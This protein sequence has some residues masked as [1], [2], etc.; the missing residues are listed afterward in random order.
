MGMKNNPAIPGRAVLFEPVKD[1]YGTRLALVFGNESKGGYCPFYEKHCT[2]CDLGGGEGLAFD[3]KMNLERLEFFKKHYEQTLPDVHHL[4]LYNSGS[5]LNP[6]ELSRKTLKDIID[7]T[8]SLADCKVVSFDSRELYVTDANIGYIVSNLREDQQARIILGI[9]SQDD[10]IRMEKLNKPMSRKAIEN[11]FAAAGKYEGRVGVDVNIIF[12][13][14]ELVGEEA[15]ADAVKTAE[16]GL[17]LGER[18]GVPVDLNVHPYY[19]S[20]KGVGVFPEHS[21][22]DISDAKKALIVIKELL[23]ARGSEANLFVG[24]ED[25]AHDQEQD[26]RTAELEH[27]LELFHRFN[28]AQDAGLLKD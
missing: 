3:H 15:I 13:P 5:V 11:A 18:Y 14:P 19:P 28:E 24:W 20:R 9:E 2:H 17:D 7:F 26:K 22:A 23:D 12:Q 8:V 21:R 10:G 6:K 4:V 27:E 16:Y 1:A 25:E